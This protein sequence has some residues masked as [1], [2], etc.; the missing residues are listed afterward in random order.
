[1]RGQDS[2][3][4]A[5][6]AATTHT[7]ARWRGT[8]TSPMARSSSHGRVEAVVAVD[9]AAHA[10]LARRHEIDHHPVPREHLEDAREE[11]VREEH[12][13]RHH[14]DHRDALLVG[15]GPG[16]AG[17]GVAAAV[18]TVPGCAGSKVFFTRTGMPARTAGWMV[19]GCSTLAPKYASSAASSKD[20]AGMVW[21]SG[22][23]RG[24]ALITPGTSV[25][26]SISS[27]PMAAPRM[28]A[29]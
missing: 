24:S 5:V 19:L 23:T 15:D 1:M 11:A 14:V 2:R 9:G 22:T 18:I 13:R 6:P 12:A 3:A 10:H 20:S 8:V 17:V 28:A 29:V 16:A 25:Q 7:S 21:A 4:A 27:A 26:I